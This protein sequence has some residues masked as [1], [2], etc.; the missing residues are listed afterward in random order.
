MDI[1]ERLEP[2]QAHQKDPPPLSFAPFGRTLWKSDT[3][4]PASL[5]RMTGLLVAPAGVEPTM[6]ESKSPALPLGDGASCQILYHSL[7]FSTRGRFH[8]SWK[9]TFRIKA[10]P[11]RDPMRAQAD[12][13]DWRNPLSQNLTVLPAPP[14]GELFASFRSAQIKL[15]L[16]GQISPAPGENV[17]QRQKGEQVARSAG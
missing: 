4:S 11:G 15:P 12:S 14:R 8:F 6:G 3:K 10:S 9:S 13:L 5:F 1:P 2:P 16:R 7:C 17:A